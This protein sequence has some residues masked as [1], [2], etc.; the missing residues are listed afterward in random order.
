MGLSPLHEDTVGNPIHLMLIAVCTIALLAL[1]RDR[2]WRVVTIY[3]ICVPVGLLLIASY[4]KW[5]PWIARYHLPSFMLWSPVVGLMLATFPNKEGGQCRRSTASGCSGPLGLPNETRP[6]L[7][8][9]GPRGVI[10]TDRS[11][12]NM[13][14]VSGYFMNFP[15]LR[16]GLPWSRGVCA[17]PGMLA[18]WA[19]CTEQ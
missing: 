3:S 7:G 18:N 15:A 4:L 8:Q 17:S 16:R 6:L 11:I 9:Y 14:R 13:S 2:K 1:W 12:V 5:A 10:N 19:G